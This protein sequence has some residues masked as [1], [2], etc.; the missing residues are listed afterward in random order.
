MEAEAQLSKLSSE[1]EQ[2]EAKEAEI[3]KDEER[4]E[5]LRSANAKETEELL[6]KQQVELRKDIDKEKKR[7]QSL[8]KLAVSVI[9]QYIHDVDWYRSSIILVHNVRVH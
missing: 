4:L 5:K 2:L 6:Q 3:K 1:R 7:L 9:L 8:K